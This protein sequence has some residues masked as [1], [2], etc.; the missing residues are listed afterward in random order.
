MDVFCVFFKSNSSLFA[1][2]LSSPTVEMI[3]NGEDQKGLVFGI[4]KGEFLLLALL[5][6]IID[7]TEL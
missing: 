3:L 1:L 5:A 4:N 6:E 7:N 2:V